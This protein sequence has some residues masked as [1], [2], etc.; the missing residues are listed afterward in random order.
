MLHN[1]LLR[2]SF[3]SLFTQLLFRGS[4]VVRFLLSVTSRGVFIQLAYFA[5]IASKIAHRQS[6]SA[7]RPGVSIITM[8]L[9]EAPSSP[10]TFRNK[11]QCSISVCGCTNSTQRPPPPGRFGAWLSGA[12][13]PAVEAE[14]G[15][16]PKASLSI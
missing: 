13:C 4:F 6:S 9:L 16:V 14:R 3:S 7:R 10:R 2:R 15:Q 12:S 1:Q 5:V 8:V 11:P